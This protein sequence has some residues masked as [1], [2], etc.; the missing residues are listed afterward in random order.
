MRTVTR[1]AAVIAVAVLGVLGAS[2][3]WAHDVVAPSQVVGGTSTTVTLAVVNEHDLPTDG[4]EA[5]LP[6]G[7]GYA[8]HEQVPGWKSSLVKKS[9][10][11][12]AIRWTGGLLQSNE[13]G[14][15][16]LTGTPPKQPGSLV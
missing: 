13:T 16:V 5:R 15:F 9:G 12:S 14:E 10:A 6:A 3:A 1:L 11:V 2:P 8:S 4:V 7:F